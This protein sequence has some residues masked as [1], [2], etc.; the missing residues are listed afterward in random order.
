VARIMYASQ[1]LVRVSVYTEMERIRVSAVRNN[2]PEGVYTALLYQSGWFLQWKEGPGD[3]LL[4]VMDRVA[5]DTRHHSLRIVHSS[6]GPRL[7]SG[8]WSMAIVQSNEHADELSAR[9]A[10]LRRDMDRGVQYGPPE[11]WRRLS[12]PP[13]RGAAGPVTGPDPDPLQSILVC[14]AS[15][16]QP[17]ELVQWL[18]EQ[19]GGEVVHRRYAGARDLDVG[20]DYVDSPQR[21]RVLRVIAMARKGLAVPLTRA[22]LADYSHLVMLLSAE[23]EH[24][25]KLM[26]LVEQACA[27]MRKSPALLGVGGTPQAHSEMLALANRHGMSYLDAGSPAGHHSADRWRVIEPHL[28]RWNPAEDSAWPIVPLLRTG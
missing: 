17:F 5:R 26:G 19:Y 10:S 6:R 11:V 7:L 13:W 18:S 15:G 3:A 28:A 25:R 16:P 20:T 4:R 2:I 22:F 1:A 8:P 12:M 24:N 21:D 14:S 27:G 9:V 23:A